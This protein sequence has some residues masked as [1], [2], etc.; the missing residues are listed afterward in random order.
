[1][2]LGLDGRVAV[3]TGGSR[4]IGKAI[5]RML[6]AEGS[7][8]AIV[9]RDPGR[10][11]TA[12]GELSAVTQAK[13]AGFACDTGSTLA[14]NRMV[15]EVASRLGGIDILVNCAGRAGRLAPQP[16]LADITE[17]DAWADIN[18][19]V[20]GYLRCIRAVVP[21]MAERGGGRIVN[22]SGLASRQT[23]ATVRSMRNAAVTAMTKNLADE[24]AP[25][26]IAVCVVHPG[27]VRTEATA[28]AVAARAARE[29]STPE[30]VERQLGSGTN[31]GRIVTADEVASVVA[32]LAS[33]RAVAVNGDGVPAGGG[34]RGWIYY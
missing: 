6:A 23:G 29:Y 32:F 1:M 33:P 28:E 8:V 4:G 13:V 34:A 16:R 24:L 31:L 7:S 20:M 19:K 25:Q 27:F 11:T 18:V 22:I 10:L 2:D 15:D 5:A 12:A 21:F 26:G 30:Q 3:V 9:A 17:D 14:V